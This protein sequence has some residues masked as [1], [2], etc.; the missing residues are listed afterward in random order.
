M[1]FSNLENE[2]ELLDRKILLNQPAR[3]VAYFERV[4]S[5]PGGSL[6]LPGYS[7]FGRKTA[8]RIVAARQ[9][10][11]IFSSKVFSG[12]ELNNFKHDMKTVLQLGT[13]L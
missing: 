4:L 7:G 8:I 11:K 9:S 2:G 5:Q 13:H 6:F 3:I 10:A 12:Y 1:V